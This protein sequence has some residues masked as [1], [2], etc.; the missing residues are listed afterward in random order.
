MEL[1]WTCVV[2]VIGKIHDWLQAR[3]RSV[4]LDYIEG[5]H[6]SNNEHYLYA[7][8]TCTSRT[9]LNSP[10]RVDS[11]IVVFQQVMNLKWLRVS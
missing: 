7:G 10:S 1:T 11:M 3:S 5:T 2:I 9:K 4:S 6:K 8:G